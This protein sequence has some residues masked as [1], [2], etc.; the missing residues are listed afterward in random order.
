MYGWSSYFLSFIW[1]NARKYATSGD[2]LDVV[3]YLRFSAD[4]FYRPLFHCVI[5]FYVIYLSRFSPSRS[6]YRFKLY[7][8]PE[9]DAKPKCFRDELRRDGDIGYYYS[10]SPNRERLTSSAGVLC[11][12][13]WASNHRFREYNSLINVLPVAPSFMP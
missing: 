9:C 10:A 7:R 8:E 5:A 11:K 2:R 1:N 6:W 12:A 13:S 4:L 3:A